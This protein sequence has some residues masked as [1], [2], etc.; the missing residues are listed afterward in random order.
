M[1]GYKIL[2]KDMV[3]YVAKMKYELGVEYSIDEEISLVKN[4]G[5]HFC[6]NIIEALKWDN[7]WSV[8]Y[9]VFEVDTL[10]GE[11]IEGL[12]TSVSSKIKLVRELDSKEILKRIIDAL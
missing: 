7:T 9:R 11:V 12:Y 2:D 4:K 8:D 3:S 6:T 1:T 10:D 5:F